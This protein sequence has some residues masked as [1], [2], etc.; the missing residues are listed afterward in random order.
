MN[1][2]KNRNGHSLKTTKILMH[3]ILHIASPLYVSFQLYNLL[4]FYILFK[5][6]FFSLLLVKYL[7]GISLNNPIIIYKY[8]IL[9][10]VE[11]WVLEIEIFHHHLLWEQG[12]PE[13]VWCHNTAWQNQSSI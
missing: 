12:A 3:W 2:T 7:G 4:T 6:K 8:L 9:P 13:S 10:S 11:A 5:N 1:I